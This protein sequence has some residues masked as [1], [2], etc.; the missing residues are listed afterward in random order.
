MDHNSCVDGALGTSGGLAEMNAAS[1]G[2]TVTDDDA[3]TDSG[4]ASDSGSAIERRE[5]EPCARITQ[6][7]TLCNTPPESLYLEVNLQASETPGDEHA[8]VRFYDGAGLAVNEFRVAPE[9]RNG[10]VSFTSPPPEHKCLGAGCRG[11]TFNVI[12]HWGRRCFFPGTFSYRRFLCDDIECPCCDDTDIES[13]SEYDADTEQDFDTDD[14][15]ACRPRG[16]P[17]NLTTVAIDHDGA[18][19]KVSFWNMAGEAAD[20]HYVFD[21]HSTVEHLTTQIKRDTGYPSIAV[22]DDACAVSRCQKLATYCE[23][24]TLTIGVATEEDCASQTTT[25]KIRWAD[26][27]SD[28]EDVA[29][30]EL[31][32]QLEQPLIVAS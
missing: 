24:R 9:Q 29:A 17:H 20:F 2:G 13:D 25:R 27:C 15:V 31:S 14:A 21:P 4:S 28:D 23:R 5:L 11:E 7:V 16:K 3:V 1:A 22:Y 30:E 19:L 18:D 10:C 12:I 8:C 6:S 32:A 26:L